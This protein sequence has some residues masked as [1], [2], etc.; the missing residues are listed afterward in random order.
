M[1]QRSLIIPLILVTA[2][3]LGSCTWYNNRMAYFNTYYNIGRIMSEAEDQFAFHDEGKRTKPRVL[4]PG[5]D[6]FTQK[7]ETAPGNTMNFLQAFVIE[8]AKLQPVQTKVDSVLIKGSK[9]L[10]NYGQTEY[11]EGTLF[12]MSKA[13]F[14][15]SEWVASQQKCVEMVE[16]FP[17]GEYSPDG[18]LLLAKNYLLQRKISQGEVALSKC[19]D[20][21]WY[22]ERYDI[23]SEAYRIQAEMA[24]EAG[25][26][27]KAVQPYK[28]AVAQSEDGE[29]RAKW[30]VDVASIYY[31][32]GKFDLAEKAFSEVFEYT[33]DAVATFEAKLYR[34]AS[35]TQLKRYDEAKEILDDMEDN[36]SYEEWK[37][38][39]AAEQL[40]LERAKNPDPENETVLAQE[41]KTDT[42]FVGRPEV[43]AQNFQKG[44]ELYKQGRY[45]EALPYFARAKVI[46]TPVYE[47]ANKY[48][49]LIKQWE[50]QH[51]KIKTL[52]FVDKAAMR[53][54]MA[55]LR[56]K[57]V[58][59]LGRVFEQFGDTDSA[60]YYYRLAHDSTAETDVEKSRYLFAQSRLI[61]QAD[62]ESADSLLEV[63]TERYP[64]S[65]YGRQANGD[66]GFSSDAIVEDDAEMFRSASSFR[67][68]GEY[69][70][71][72][73]RYNAIVRDY[74]QGTHAARALYALGWMYER[75]MINPDSSR[76]YYQLLVDKYP[77]SEYARDIR[78]SLEFALAKING[79]EVQDSLL[80]RDLDKDLYERA[81]AGEKDAF[82][83]MLD[84]NQDMINGNLQQ[85]QNIP[86]MNNVPG[87]NGSLG[88]PRPI[89]TTPMQGG[90]GQGQGQGQGPGGGLGRPLGD[91]FGGNPQQ[92]QSD[93]TG[94]RRP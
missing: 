81:K 35:L 36:R 69:D 12:S 62:P 94:T 29:Q 7:A 67:R 9:I 52:S 5:S 74:P 45:S 30:Q 31:R 60:L 20:V 10:A 56:S 64:N 75:E 53:D 39:V 34:A 22:K 48:F 37:S 40:A 42:S 68:I 78:P 92:D 63:I 13:Y 14:F 15:R 84:N 41:R 27:N 23:L 1:T 57:E 8:R 87:M 59:A 88:T 77:T 70:M 32:A 65:Q 17:E 83:Q 80:L 43:L 3:S 66:L 54:T 90:Q 2:L 6:E 11:V 18:H 82:Q 89:G 49:G 71:A 51:R 58:Y 21:A 91:P 28:Q 86:G 25:D 33:P 76:Y 4:V 85:F 73:T 46:R 24:I 61:R 72:S 55:M 93:S 38:F 47:V 44:M 50:D 19:I 16:K 26:L 79:V